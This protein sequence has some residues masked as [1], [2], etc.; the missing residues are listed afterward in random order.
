VSGFGVQ[1]SRWTVDFVVVVVFV[2]GSVAGFKRRWAD[3]GH[4][5]RISSMCERVSVKREGIHFLRT[6]TPN[7]YSKHLL[8]I[9]AH[10]LLSPK[11]TTNTTTTTM[12]TVHCPPSSLNTA[13][14]AVAHRVSRI[15]STSLF[16]LN[17][18]QIVE[19]HIN[20]FHIRR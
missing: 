15:F 11:T 20:C 17:N 18:H 5:H 10:G 9:R 1:G 14:H 19:Q 7:N 3:A 16:F 6:L 12:T 4:R 13:C 8:Q 2:V